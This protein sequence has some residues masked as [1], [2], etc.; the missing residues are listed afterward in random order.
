AGS[1]PSKGRGVLLPLLLLLSL[2]R[3]RSSELLPGAG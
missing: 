2:T 1:A 3:R